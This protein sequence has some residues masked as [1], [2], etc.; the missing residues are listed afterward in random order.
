MRP[1]QQ[2]GN[3]KGCARA[4][5]PIWY[6]GEDCLVCAERQAS[7]LREQQMREDKNKALNEQQA[8]LDEARRLRYLQQKRA[9]AEAASAGRMVAGLI[10]T[11]TRR[12]KIADTINALLGATTEPEFIFGPILVKQATRLAR[13]L[14]G[15]A[16]AP[17]EAA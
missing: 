14:V 9:D 7:A 4:H 10:E 1:R 8:A 17:Q 11:G 16:P 5:E 15:L 6:K 2:I 3:W 12:Q 13:E